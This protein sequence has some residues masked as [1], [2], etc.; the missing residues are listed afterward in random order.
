V[1]LTDYIPSPRAV[2]ILAAILILLFV[3]YLWFGRHPA[4]PKTA[5]PPADSGS[6]A[7]STSAPPSGLSADSDVYPDG[8]QAPG[9]L[10]SAL[11]EAA[12]DHKNVLLDFG[13]NWCPDCRV[14]EI[15]FHDPANWQLLNANYVLVP[16]NIGQYDQNTAIAAKYGIPL[17]KGVPALAVLDSGGR[18][19]YSQRDGEF[20]AMRG[21]DPS[22]VTDFLKKWKPSGSAGPAAGPAGS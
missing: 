4:A 9:D 16:I 19:I 13:G 21:M 12:K 20:E 18:V 1:P 11:A 5:P 15:Y 22:S 17:K 8:A 6:S 14:L 3:S 7:A 10:N 2:L